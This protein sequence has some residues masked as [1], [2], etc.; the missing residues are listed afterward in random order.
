MKII[1]M[2]G[3]LLVLLIL[4]S[5][6][7]FHAFDQAAEIDDLESQISLQKD[8]LRFMQSVSN[9]ALSTC[10]VSVPA[11]EE[12]AKANGHNTVLWQNNAA[13]VGPFRVKRKVGVPCVA[14]M[15][16]VG[17]NIDVR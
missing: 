6:S 12:M 15:Q 16:L 14:E 9:S 10:S 1:V 5:V 4:A 8:A 3:L 11:F 2:Y 13:L 7:L 17:L